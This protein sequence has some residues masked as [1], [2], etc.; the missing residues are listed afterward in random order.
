MVINSIVGNILVW[1]LV[2]HTLLYLIPQCHILFLPNGLVVKYGS[3]LFTS[4]V[5]AT[6]PQ[7][8][9]DCG[10][11]TCWTPHEWWKIWS[12]CSVSNSQL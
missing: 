4:L 9:R 6:N 10:Q 11:V 12:F 8:N 2:Q 5:D 7:W 3:A 1:M